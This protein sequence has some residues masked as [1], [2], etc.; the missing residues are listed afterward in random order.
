MQKIELPA[1]PEVLK[2]EPKAR[3]LFLVCDSIGDFLETTAKA[4][5]SNDPQSF[6][7]NMSADQ[8]R[9]CLR[10]GNMELVAQADAV[11]SKVESIVPIA[12][13]WHI[14]N[15][16]VGGVPNVPA[17]L[18]GHP[19][20]MRRRERSMSERAPLAI[21]ADITSSGD[22]EASTV[23]KRGIMI[24]ALLRALTA[25]RP[26]ELFVTIPI[27]EKELGGTIVTRMETAPLDLARA[28]HMIAHQSV[29]RGLGYKTIQQYHPKSHGWLWGSVALERSTAK[30]SL[31]R[32]MPLGSEVLYI[33]PVHNMDKALTEPETWLRQML[34]AHGGMEIEA[35]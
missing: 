27:G 26:V 12:H 28:V 1:V 21:V 15:D 31:S 16:V 22:L 10:N 17:Y 5:W 8:C 7:S 30:Q 20:T 2:K 13:A 6:Y 14:V 35:A 11:L 25:M 23:Q 4:D 33:P 32:I 29:A 34:Q 24:F 18:A 9:N 19:L 3:D